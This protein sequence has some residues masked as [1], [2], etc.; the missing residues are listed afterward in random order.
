MAELLPATRDDLAEIAGI[1]NHYILNSAATFHSEKMSATE[2][3]EFL[4]I[5]HPRYASFSI[6]DH[7]D[8]I[9]FSYL[10]HYKK[11]QAYDR[12]AEMSL[13]FD[14]LTPLP[15]HPRSPGAFSKI[16]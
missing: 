11:R 2:L 7:G 14:C 13:F 16:P 15:H 6:R 12:S 1:Y 9:G 5:S 4:Y 8:L 10:T 3:E